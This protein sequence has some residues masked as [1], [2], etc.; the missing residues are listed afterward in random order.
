MT[1]YLDQIDDAM[2]NVTGYL[3]CFPID[4]LPPSLPL[5]TGLICNFETAEEG[6]SHWVTCCHTPEKLFYM[7]SFGCLPPTH[8]QTLFEN[9]GGKSS[10]NDIDFQGYFSDECGMYCVFF[11]THALNGVPIDDILFKLLKPYPSKFN[12]KTVRDFFEEVGKD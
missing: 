6:G 7:D 11:L 4:K 3:G 1:L 2:K 9:T 12:E 5:N 8:I 10:Y